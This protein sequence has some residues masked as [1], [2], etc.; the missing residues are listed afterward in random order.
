MED[1]HDINV[2]INIYE[3]A[4]L[5]T[6]KRGIIIMFTVTFLAKRYLFNVFGKSLQCQSLRF[7]TQEILE[8]EQLAYNVY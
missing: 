5:K 4:L 6:K 8:R 1:R 7:P 3:Y 2:I